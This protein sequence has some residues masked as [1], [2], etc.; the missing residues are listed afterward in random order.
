MHEDTVSLLCKADEYDVVIT[1]T[2]H[3]LL[4]LLPVLYLSDYHFHAAAGCWD[5]RLHLF[6]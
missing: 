1:T 6:R 4:L 3:L 5:S 2:L